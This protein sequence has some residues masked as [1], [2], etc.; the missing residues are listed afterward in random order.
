MEPGWVDTGLASVGIAARAMGA[1]GLDG[2]VAQAVDAAQMRAEVR[3][4]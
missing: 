1:E 2:L 4:R 3:A